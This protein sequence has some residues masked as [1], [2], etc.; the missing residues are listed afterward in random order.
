MEFTRASQV[1]TG[2]LFHFSITTSRRCVNPNPTLTYQTINTN[3]RQDDGKIHT[4]CREF[5]YYIG[6]LQKCC[7][8]KVSKE[9]TPKSTRG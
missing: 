3:L 1:A 5:I 6:L 4:D 8:K 2:V 9:I 7:S